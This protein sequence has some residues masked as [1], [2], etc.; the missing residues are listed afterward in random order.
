[1]RRGRASEGEEDF[2]RGSD[3]PCD[4][5]SDGSVAHFRIMI[6]GGSGQSRLASRQRIASFA[7][8]RGR[9]RLARASSD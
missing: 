4:L 6:G 5:R 1:M 7:F 9:R 8:T 3:G 2:K